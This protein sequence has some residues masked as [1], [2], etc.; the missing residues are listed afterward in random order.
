MLTFLCMNSFPI[1]T[2][3]FQVCVVTFSAEFCC[4]SFVLAGTEQQWRFGIWCNC[5]HAY[6]TFQYLCVLFHSLSLATQPWLLPGSWL[7]LIHKCASYRDTNQGISTILKMFPFSRC[8]P[9]SSPHV[10]LHHSFFLSIY[11]T[12]F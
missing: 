1:G 4:P 6:S 12:V 9:S 11:S 10:Q 7:Q 8:Y 5:L 2:L 3:L